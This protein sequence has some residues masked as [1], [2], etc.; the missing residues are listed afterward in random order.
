MIKQIITVIFTFVFCVGITFGIYSC[1]G[2]TSHEG[3]VKVNY[4]IIYPDT[5]IVKDSTFY[6]E[7]YSDKPTPFTSSYKGSNYIIIGSYEFEHTTCP[8]RINSYKI[9]K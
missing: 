4:S 8:I 3:I 5:I 2:C 6:V 9:I 7:Y 1:T